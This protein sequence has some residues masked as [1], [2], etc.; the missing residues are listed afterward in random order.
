MKSIKDYVRDRELRQTGGHPENAAFHSRN[1]RRHFEG[2]SEVKARGADGKI[3]T[4]RV[5]TGV[6]HRARLS[7]RQIT[8][9]RLAYAAL[10]LIAVALFFFAATRPAESNTVVYVTAL[11][12]LCVVTLG[13]LMWAL[14]NILTA[15]RDMTLGEYRYVDMVKRAALF[16]AAALGLTAL[17]TLIYLLA[18]PGGSP[19]CTLWFLLCA[20]CCLGI[21]LM[22]SRVT[23]DSFLSDQQPPEDSTQISL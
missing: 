15:G 4:R 22:E 19:L 3:R 23:Y 17:G 5:Y 9:H 16:S 20:L 18:H 1:Y 10:W 12:G 2:F 21:Y 14:Y 11:Q 8:L 7:D 6:Y 13:W